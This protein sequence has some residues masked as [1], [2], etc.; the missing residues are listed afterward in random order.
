MDRLDNVQPGTEKCNH[1]ILCFSHA[2]T[3]VRGSL[4]WSELLRLVLQCGCVLSS[5]KEEEI[6]LD[7][8]GAEPQRCSFWRNRVKAP[9]ATRLLYILLI[10][11]AKPEGILLYKTTVLISI[12]LNSINISDTGHL[13]AY[14]VF[15]HI[16]S[17]LLSDFHSVGGKAS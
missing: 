6:K 12:K 5:E 16:N 7:T 4:H 3:K 1:V 15:T 11:V 10:P 9:S 8:Q 13:T 14:C 2:V 17:A